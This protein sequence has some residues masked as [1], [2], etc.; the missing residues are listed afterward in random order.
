ML[1]A[2]GSDA[3]WLVSVYPQKRDIKVVAQGDYSL[4]AQRESLELWMI[5]DD[6][7]PRSLGLLPLHGRGHLQMP[8][9]VPM[10]AKPV[11]A[12]SR[13]PHGGSPTGLPSSEEHTSELQSLMRTSYAVFCLTQKKSHTR[14]ISTT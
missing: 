2:Q 7:K 6:G 3:L 5:G 11:L 10:Q 13:E 14:N 1:Q 9:S 4:D 12:I 8:A